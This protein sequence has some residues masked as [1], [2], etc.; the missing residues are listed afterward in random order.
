M[1]TCTKCNTEY[2]LTGFHKGTNP[3]GYR[4]WCKICVA[5]YKKQYVA[6]NGIRIRAQ[7]K[8]YSDK[9]YP[10][11]REYY[12]QR[13]LSRKEFSLEQNRLWRKNN[14][15]SHAARESKR[16]ASKLQ[17]TPLWLTEDDHWM[18]EQTYE[19]AALR[20]K[21][22][23]FSWHV[24]HIIPMQGKTVSGLHVPWNLQVIPAVE[25]NRKYNKL[26]ENIS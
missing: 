6:K 2:L 3:D 11:R 23:G 12:Q 8:E 9:K 26:V 13:Y 19:L 5:E 24:D 14:P 25:N 10:E 17:R 22:L 16:R 4:T 21:M 20:T 15:E 18:I 1:K 7:Q